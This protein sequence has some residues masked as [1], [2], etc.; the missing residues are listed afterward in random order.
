MILLPDLYQNKRICLL[1]NASSLTNFNIN[2]NNYDIV[3]GINRIYQ[4]KY[5]DNIHILYNAL[6]KKDWNNTTIMTSILKSK[7]QFKCFI[8][9]PWGAKRTSQ[10][11]N[12]LSQCNFYDTK[13]FLFCR[14]IV[15]QVE[16]PK[17]PLTGIAAL[18]HILLSGGNNV[19]LFGFD[20]YKTKYIDNLPVFDHRKY[21]DIEAN[22][23][24][25]INTINNPNNKITWWQ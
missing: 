13:Q 21:H 6:S 9:C 4:T 25:L 14:N 2:F 19:D 3:V 22:K 8:A 17:R 5:I 11:K 12:I 20:F 23:E 18:N 24:F 1:G 16:V 10:I 7:P 15:R